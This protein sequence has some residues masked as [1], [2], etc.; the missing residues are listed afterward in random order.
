MEFVENGVVAPKGFKANGIH[1]GI[2]SNK[3]KIDL[4]LITSDV[5]ASAAAVY[6]SNLVKGAPIYVT[7]NNLADGYAQAMICNSGNANTC[8]KNGIEIAS[9]TCKILAKSLNINENDIIVASTGVIGLPLSIEPFKAHMD[10]IVS[11]LGNTKMHS[12]LACQGIMTTDTRKKEVAVKFT[13]DN[14]ECYI[15]AI[16]KGSGMIHP[17]MATMLCFITTDVSIS[18]K[19]LEKALKESVNDSFNMLSVDGDTSANDTCSIMANG[20]AGNKTIAK[21]ND[22]YY[23]FLEALKL[24]NITLAKEMAKD[25]EGATKLIIAEVKNAKTVNDAKLVAKSVICSSLLKSAMFGADANWGR[26]LCAIGYSKADV[27]VL[28]VDMAFASKKG[29]LKVCENGYGIPFSEELA[30]EIL[31]EDEITIK[32]NLNDGK[33]EA[34]AFG[35][36]LTYD[37]VKINGDYRS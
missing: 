11:G 29:Y 1:A 24:V 15:G 32:I 28:K 6:T 30:K 17:N 3:S 33:G 36:D 16:T 34:S 10:E 14:K 9:E 12:D 26:V 21:E 37:Y 7:K 8:N 20:L 2:R 18:P 23:T 5:K 19:M 22:D 25:G 4:A 31:L 13:L 35:C 27:D